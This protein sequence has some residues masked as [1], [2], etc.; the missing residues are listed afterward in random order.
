VASSCKENPPA[1]SAARGAADRE[2]PERRSFDN[3]A[4][5][6]M[7]QLLV[8]ETASASPLHRRSHA[9]PDLPNAAP[10]R[11]ELLSALRDT[12]TAAR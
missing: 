10:R 4:E 9:L 7:I 12:G 6:P 3:G 5:R 11:H 1:I 2:A 8:N